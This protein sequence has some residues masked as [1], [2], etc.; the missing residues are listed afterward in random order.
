MVGSRIFWRLTKKDDWKK[1]KCTS[2][3]IMAVRGVVSWCTNVSASNA[4]LAILLGI[5]ELIS[6]FCLYK[7]INVFEKLKQFTIRK[8]SIREKIS[9]KKGITSKNI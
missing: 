6:S 3:V 9:R 8:T 7:E 4:W 2:Y 1:I 5:R